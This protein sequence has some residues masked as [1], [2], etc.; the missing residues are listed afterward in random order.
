MEIIDFKDLLNKCRC[1]FQY[2]EKKCDKIEI[3]LNHKRNFLELTKIE[4]R[5]NEEY[6][7]FFCLSCDENLKKSLSFMK[8]AKERQTKLYEELKESL[9]KPTDQMEE[10]EELEIIHEEHQNFEEIS[11][12]IPTPKVINIKRN[13]VLPSRYRTNAQE[14]P[15][16]QQI[17]SISKFSSYKTHLKL[18]LHF[19]KFQN[20]QNVKD[21]SLVMH[22]K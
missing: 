4:L 11:E 5:D 8:Q 7:T 6:S 18:F 12:N 13:I 2:L 14:I 21:H 15:S 3:N 16:E 20:D 19:R 22:V 10:Y 17:V 1:C 9:N